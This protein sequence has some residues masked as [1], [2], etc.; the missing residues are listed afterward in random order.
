[1]I[2]MKAIPGDTV[3]LRSLWVS[4]GFDLHRETLVLVAA[5]DVPGLAE[6]LGLAADELFKD[7]LGGNA[8]CVVL[9]PAVVTSI[10]PILYKPQPTYP[11]AKAREL[12]RHL[13]KPQQQADF[14][15]MQRKAQEEEAREAG[16]REMERQQRLKAEQAA[17]EESQKRANPMW[18]IKRLEE[19]LLGETPPK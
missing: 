1:M 13:A 4:P 19:M 2:D 14:R 11:A 5:A 8:P 3:R 6:R 16:R 12:T 9:G 10:E 17:I 15:E 7:A 18:R